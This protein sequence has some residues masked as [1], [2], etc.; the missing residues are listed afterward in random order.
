MLR[1]LAASQDLLV[2]G[3]WRGT[4]LDDLLRQQLAPFAERGVGFEMNGPRVML[5]ASAAQTLGLALHELAT[6]ATKY[7][8]WSSPGGN[9]A[10]SWDMATGEQPKLHLLWAESG[11]PPVEVPLRKGFGHIVFEHMV[12]QSAQGEVKIDYNPAGLRWSVSLPIDNISE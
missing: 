3:Q 7:G 6:N 11:G 5:S 1:A 2:E 10:I 8:A 9:V 4:V 12:E